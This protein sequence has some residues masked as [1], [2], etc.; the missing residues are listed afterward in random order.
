VFR[1]QLVF[2]GKL[3]TEENWREEQATKYGND[4]IWFCFPKAP[5]R[6]M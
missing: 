6:P 2:F 4:F 5:H 3:K 1:D